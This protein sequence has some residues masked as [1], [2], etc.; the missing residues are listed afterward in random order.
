MDSASTPDQEVSKNTMR[1]TANQKQALID[2]L[3]L[4]G[5]LRNYSRPR[6]GLTW[7]Q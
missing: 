4:E 7:G 2:N 1:I 6:P 5:D 3:Q